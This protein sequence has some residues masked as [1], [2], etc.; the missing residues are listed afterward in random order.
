MAYGPGVPD[1]HDVYPTIDNCY[2]AVH[3]EGSNFP[4]TNIDS[5]EI[6]ETRRLGFN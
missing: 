1:T 2:R 4:D 3:M 6:E 5:T